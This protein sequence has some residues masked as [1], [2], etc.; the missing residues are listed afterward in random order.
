MSMF[1]F[2]CQETAKNE[3]CTVKGVCGKTD[4]VSNLQ[5]VLV[6]VAKGVAAYSSQ[7]RNAG[8]RYDKVD[9]YLFRSLLSSIK[10]ANLYVDEII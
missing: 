2:Q 7:L 10:K 4:E 8:K 5:D 1:C 9:E 6:F 3:G